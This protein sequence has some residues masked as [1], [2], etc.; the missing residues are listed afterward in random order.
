MSDVLVSDV[1]VSDVTMGDVAMGDVVDPT[2]L[3]A[4][5]SEGSPISRLVAVDQLGAWCEAIRLACVLELEARGEAGQL[6]GSSSRTPH[7]N[8]ALRRRARVAQESPDLLSALQRG[9]TTPAHLDHLAATLRRLDAPQRTDLLAQGARLLAAA[10]STHA[11]EFA[12]WLREEERRLG[13]RAGMDTLEQ[14]RRSVRMRGRTDR[15]TG[16]RVYT[17]TLDPV[18]G[19]SFDGRLDAATESLF[20]DRTP[21]SCPADPIERQGFL[22]AHALLELLNGK[23]GRPGRPEVVVVLDTTVPDGP[24]HVDWGLSV[25]IPERVLFE[26]WGR[27]DVYAVVVRNGVVIHAPGTLNLGRLTR[28]A[29]RAQRRALRALYSRCAVPGC[30]TS[31]DRCKIHHAHW[32][33]HGGFTDLCNLLPLCVRHHHLVHEGGWQLTLAPDRSLTIRQPHGRVVTTGP[34]RRWAP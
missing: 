6:D 10:T 7:E 4:A 21:S 28:L 18:S 26:L 20:H 14:Q 19:L 12:R 3:V 17:L 16:M 5:A 8:E 9:A 23:G 25:E 30:D 27:A 29:N 24:P 22:R 13:R 1:L 33:R 31:F 2:A 32:W 15:A 34:P 11:N